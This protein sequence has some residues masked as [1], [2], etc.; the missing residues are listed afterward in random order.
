[1]A[2]EGPA[3]ARS[4]DLWNVKP[5]GLGLPQHGVPHSVLEN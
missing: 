1:M 5:F 3:T 4:A 2:E